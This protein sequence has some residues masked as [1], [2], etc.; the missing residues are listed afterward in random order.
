MNRIAL[1][2]SVAVVTL[3]PAAARAAGSLGVA[4]ARSSSQLKADTRPATFQALNVLDGKETTVWCEGAEGDGVGE[5]LVVGFKG[6]AEIDEVRITTGDARDA[7]SFK[8]HG[9][10]KQLDLKTDEKRYSFSVVDNTTTQS[11][12][13]DPIVVDRLVLEVA[14]AVPG[15]GDEKATTCLADVIFLAKGKPINGTFLDGKLVYNKGRAMLMGVWYGGPA[16]ARDKF[17]D[18]NY[19]GTYWY[20]FKPFD[21]EV[22]AE[23]FGGKY[24]YDGTT[25][26]MEL[27]SKKW[28]ELRTMPV[29]AKDE[30]TTLE[31]EGKEIEKTL[32]GKWSEKP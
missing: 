9:R 10:V 7:A 28:V 29:A 15:D 6:A 24:T 19:D 8:A 21:P 2:V 4:Y 26:R 1:L 25:L 31:L 3:L 5:T 32:A 12:K 18:F 11:F 23:A 30:P 17:L 14:E 22:K 16:G 20:S 13:F 27:P